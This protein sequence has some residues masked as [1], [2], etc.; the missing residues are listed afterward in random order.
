M[1]ILGLASVLAA[2]PT[3]RG[4]ERV[5]HIGYAFPAGRGLGGNV[6]GSS[7]AA[8]GAFQS[9]VTLLGEQPLRIAAGGSAEV[10]CGM[11]L[12]NVRGEV[13]VELTDPPEGIAIDRVSQGEKGVSIF[14]HDDAQKA[15]PGLKGNL[16]AT[17]YRKMTF[18]DKEG[19][20]REFRALLGTLPAIPFEVVP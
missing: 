20:T 3:A 4:Q 2:V 15:K 19:K 7:G 18:T 1:A 14:L 13:Q 12:K 16:I 17:A 9:P 11:S 10:Q 6:S 5:P 8:A